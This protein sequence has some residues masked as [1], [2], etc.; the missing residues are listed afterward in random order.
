MIPPTIKTGL[1]TS[2]NDLPG[3]K[4]HLL[5]PSFPKLIAGCL[6]SVL[7]E[8]YLRIFQINSSMHSTQ[9]LKLLFF[10]GSL[11]FSVPSSFLPPSLP[12]YIYIFRLP[13]F[14]LIFHWFIFILCALVFCLHACICE[15]TGSPGTGGIDVES[16]HVGTRD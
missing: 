8:P 3:K 6:C 13:T 15:G 11:F 1:S 7:G 9:L 14:L 10:T 16:C 12:S 2:V 5:I 4:I